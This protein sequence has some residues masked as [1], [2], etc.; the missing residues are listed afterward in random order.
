MLTYRI[1]DG[2]KSDNINGVMGV[3]LKS[4]IKYIPK[5]TED[6]DFTAKDLLEFAE[7]SDSKIK[8]LE[9]IKNSGKLIKRNY[10]LMQLYNVDIPKHIKRKLKGSLDKEI[11]NLIKFKFQSMFLKDKLWAQIPNLDLWLQD[12]IILNRFKRRK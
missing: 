3:G 12:F 7:N 5:I 8:L 6:E 11:P 9:N 10:L 4:L 1:L 2:D